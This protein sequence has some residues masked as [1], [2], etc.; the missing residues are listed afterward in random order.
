MLGRQAPYV[1]KFRRRNND[2]LTIEDH[3][4]I[5]KINGAYYRQARLV[6][7]FAACHYAF[8][9]AIGL[10]LMVAT[11]VFAQRTR[12]PAD[13]TEDLN[14]RP[15]VPKG[16][17]RSGYCWIVSSASTERG[18]WRCYVG[19]Y[20]Y[21]PCFETP[22]LSEA[23]ICGANPATNE[24]GFILQ[25]TKPLP[26]A[27]WHQPLSRYS[28]WLLKL[29]DG[30]VCE[31][32][33]GTA[34]WYHGTPLLYGCSDSRC[35]FGDAP[36]PYEAELTDHVKHGR[37]WMAEKFVLKRSSTAKTIL[38]KHEWVAVEEAWR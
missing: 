13:S 24:S 16:E 37:I 26:A 11:P 5:R 12:P 8:L 31:R 29:A 6:R 9:V 4:D 30:S 28:P 20:I 14:F 27:S 19:D 34:D 21:D 1:P 32:E 36:C 25:L 18:A 17:P 33:T 3:G 38:L 7:D 22:R 35:L 15:T 2:S 23:V 10:A